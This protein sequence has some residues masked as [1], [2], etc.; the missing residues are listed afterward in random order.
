[1]KALLHWSGMAIVGEAWSSFSSS[2]DVQGFQKQSEPI[3][4][5][6][7]GWVNTVSLA[8]HVSV[9]KH[10]RAGHAPCI[11]RSVSYRGFQAKGLQLG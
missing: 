10:K 1:M 11:H 4:R 5:Q 2:G 9:L 7:N 8:R 6:S 3:R